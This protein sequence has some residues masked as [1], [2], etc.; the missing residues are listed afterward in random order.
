MSAPYCRTANEL[1]DLRLWL[2]HQWAPHG[3]FARVAAPYIDQA[4]PEG[5]RPNP[6]AYA[7]WEYDALGKA[8]LWWVS[9]DMMDLLLA[10]APGV[11][12]D[13]LPMEL[14]RPS[15]SGL[16]VFERPYQGQDANDPDNQCEVHAVLWGGTKLPPLRERPDLDQLRLERYDVALAMSSYQRVVWED[17]LRPS[18]MQMAVARGALEHAHE[19]PAGPVPMR[20]LPAE[21]D[22]PQAFGKYPD[23]VVVT[24]PHDSVSPGIHPGLSKYGSN[25][26]DPKTGG[27]TV[28][29][30]ASWCPLGRSD[31]PLID[32][33]GQAP[34]TQPEHTTASFCEDRKLLAA[35]WTLTAQEGVASTT[36]Q[37]TGRQARRRAERAGVTQGDA[38]TVRVVALRRL[39]PRHDG[40]EHASPVHHDHRWYVR[41]FWRNQPVG[42]GRAERRL[43]W[44]RPHIRGPEGAPIKTKE[45]VNAW[46]R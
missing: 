22:D 33:L 11:P 44:V 28:L 45:V 34:W 21:W 12:D 9:A 43:T 4:G 6:V 17:G 41:G 23:P 19:A 5:S 26:V 18:E 1:P 30:G 20:D 8:T 13:V 36:L 24:G 16:V 3:V 27:R 25:L 7:E 29:S 15:P 46:V 42:K 40:P 31:W 2:R 38:S 35:L 37:S 10:A 32:P 14:P 39:R